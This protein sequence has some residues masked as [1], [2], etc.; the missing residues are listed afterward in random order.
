MAK[1]TN[2]S[3]EL[4]TLLSQLNLGAMADAFADVAL[5][6][7]TEGLSHEAY[8]YE[9]A[10]LETEY[11][12]Q[13]PTARL[14]CQTGLPAETILRALARSRLSAGLQFQLERVTSAAF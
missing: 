9:L 3:T 6:A 13:R 2:R 4:L 1:T 11:R 8:L 7:A 10:R 12:T 14:V 5:P